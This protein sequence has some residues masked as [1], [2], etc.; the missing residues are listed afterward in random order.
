MLRFMKSLCMALLCIVAMAI[1]APSEES[2][3]VTDE[4]VA[5]IQGNAL[6]IAQGA[7]LEDAKKRAVEQAIG[8]LIGTQTHVENY[9]LIS[10][11]ILSRNKQYIKKYNVTSETTDSGLLRVRINAEVAFD[12]LTKDLSAIGIHVSRTQ[13]L[14][15][16]IIT[17][18][19]L[20]K[21]RFAKFKNVLQN[22]VRGI[23]GYHETSFDGT[24]AKISVESQ[25]SAQIL[26]DELLLRDFGDFTV[27]VVSLTA[28]SIEL[29]ATTKKEKN[30][31]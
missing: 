16:V 14:R 21:V 5:A 8:I 17:I 27:E 13:K 4:G 3:T 29:K 11:K 24:T 10:D 15:S 1:P 20:D 18:T 28:N 19:G 9:Q 30:K 26:S 22:Q 23:K 25:N 31:R 12:K 6:D 2:K 7:A